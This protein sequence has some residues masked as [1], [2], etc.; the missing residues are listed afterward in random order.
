[1]KDNKNINV[2]NNII[3]KFVIILKPKFCLSTFNNYAQDV[4]L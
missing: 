1:M 3:K 2:T 4:S